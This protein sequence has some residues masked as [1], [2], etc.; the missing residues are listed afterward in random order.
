M[1]W[2]NHCG[3]LN[4]FD[5]WYFLVAHFGLR[6]GKTMSEDCSQE[7]ESLKENQPEKS[8]GDGQV[9]ISGDL[10]ETGRVNPTFQRFSLDIFSWDQ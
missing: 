10:N 3:T 4:K 2:I 6:S 7:K 1:A 5:Q 9:E 8:N